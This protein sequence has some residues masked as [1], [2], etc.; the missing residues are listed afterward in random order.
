MKWVNLVPFIS[1]LV[2]IGTLALEKGSR[3]RMGLFRDLAVRRTI[4]NSSIFRAD[5]LELYKNAL[6]I[7]LLIWVMVAMIKVKNAS[8]GLRRYIA[9]TLLTTFALYMMLYLYFDVSWLAYPLICLSMIL[10]V[11]VQDLRLSYALSRGH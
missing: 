3:E 2:L 1:W 6:I 10:L 7:S 8:S 4:L 11:I 5:Q 9:V